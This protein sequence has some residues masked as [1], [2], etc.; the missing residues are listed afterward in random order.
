M[1]GKLIHISELHSSSMKI[2]ASDT[3]YFVENILEMLVNI[4][5]NSFNDQD[6][7]E[8]VLDLHTKTGISLLKLQEVIF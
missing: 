3:A 2:A 8:R 7:R 4:K 1:I 5:N 6:K